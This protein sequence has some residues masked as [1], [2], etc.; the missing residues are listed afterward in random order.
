MGPA[1]RQRLL[2]RLEASQKQAAGLLRSMAAYQDW[3]DRPGQYSFRDLAAWLAALDEECFLPGIKEIARGDNPYIEPYHWR[4]DAGPVP[5][6][7]WLERWT[8][9]RR[10]LINFMAALP[11]ESWLLA[12]RHATFGPVTLLGLLLVL[13]DHDREHLQQIEQKIS[14]WSRAQGGC[15]EPFAGPGGTA[16]SVFG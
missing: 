16:A 12:G 15:E 14:D 13:M 6:T 10:K 1:Q 4:N 8:A 9:T 7:A 3:P 2:K 5:L 11:G